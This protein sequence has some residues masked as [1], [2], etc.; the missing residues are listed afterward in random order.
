MVELPVSQGY[1]WGC[2]GHLDVLSDGDKR[3]VRVGIEKSAR[4]TTVGGPEVRT[5]AEES[6]YGQIW[7]EA[8]LNY[9]D[10]R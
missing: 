10:G 8:T 6:G 3:R 1:C 5:T 9:G 2:G 7:R 4:L